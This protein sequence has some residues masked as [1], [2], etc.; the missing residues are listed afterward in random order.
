MS[1][2][3]ISNPVL[4][5][6]HPDPS[7]LRVGTDFYI[8]T[9]T[10]EWFPGVRIH[11]SKD[12]VHWRFVGHA[13]DR[14]SQL[15][16]RGAS[17]S[18]GVW[19]PCLTHDGK[20]FYLIYTN[21][22]N[23]DRTLFTFDTP[24]YLVTADRIEGPWS[25]PAHLN[26]SGFDPSLFNDDDGRKWIVNM[27][28][29]HRKDKNHFA[30]IVLQEYS[31]KEKKLVG[32]IKHIFSGT[33]LGITEGPHLYKR[34]GWYYLVT[35]EGG[36]SWNHAVTLARSKKIDG[37]YEVHPQNPILTA[38]KSPDSGLQ[39]SGHASIV[40][41]PKGEWYM[42][43][44][45]SRPLSKM[46]RCVLGRETAIQ[47]II[48]GEDDWPR[49][50]AGGHLPQ[51][52][53]PAP[54]LVAHPWPA[55][56]ARDEFDAPKLL[57]HWATLR[58]PA[59]EETVSL[60]DRAGFLRLKGRAFFNTRHEQAFVARRQT[61]FDYDAVTCVEFEPEDFQQM[62]GLAAYYDTS[63]FYYL[64]LSRDEEL[65]KSLNIITADK[66]SYGYALDRDVSVDGWKRVYL[67]AEVR[68][69]ALRFFYSKDGSSWTPIGPLLDAS[70]LSDDYA[71]DLS[72]TG[73]FVGIACQDLSGRLKPA[74]FDFF[75]YTS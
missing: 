26:S 21:V 55:E 17:D 12:L 72:F 57:S 63:N 51:L 1:E 58:V 42:A 6:F 30:G 36:T 7:I 65:G 29:D 40:D 2:R 46:G 10:F 11:H 54:D 73:A 62:A 71:S 50:E 34:K 67:K 38:N 61:S 56:L 44:L 70:K 3:R 20:K 49:L 52:D 33:K 39:K 25:E 37:P 66:A 75:E 27:I 18:G 22:L 41:T 48:W 31:E 35:A 74:D 4:P 59:R 64:R 28:W 15:D 23:F 68:R 9:S 5:G 32:P 69:D 45:T 43:H 14:A 53:V 8:A 47:K 24:N 16:M 60:K 13:L 19:A